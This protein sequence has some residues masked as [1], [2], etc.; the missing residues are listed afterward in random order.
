METFADLFACGFAVASSEIQSVLRM[1]LL[2]V[3]SRSVTL[4]SFQLMRPI[5]AVLPTVKLVRLTV[6]A[7][8]WLMYM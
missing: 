7:S 8:D 6:V 3:K 4:R 1:R 5:V 2:L